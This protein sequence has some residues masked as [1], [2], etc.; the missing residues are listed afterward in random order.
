MN[1][2]IHI[3]RK[4]LLTV[5]DHPFNRAPHLNE[6]ML[7]KRG[8]CRTREN[9]AATTTPIPSMTT[10]IAFEDYDDVGGEEEEEDIGTTPVGVDN[11]GQGSGL[12]EPEDPFVTGLPPFV[13]L[14]LALQANSV[15]FWD[16]D[17][18][19]YR[20]LSQSFF[21]LIFGYSTGEIYFLLKV[22]GIHLYSKSVEFM[23]I[24]IK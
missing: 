5:Y 16:V 1:T 20:Y 7:F 10:D 3:K 14:P 17:F 24:P 13:E 11:E 18:I 23:V 9:D 21:F 19:P 2:L 4:Y 22:D 6:V 8:D 15:E 12:T